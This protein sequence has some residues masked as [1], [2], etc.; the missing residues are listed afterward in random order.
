MLTD[1]KFWYIIWQG[2]GEVGPIL[3]VA[4]Y[5]SEGEMQLVNTEKG[6]V[7]RYV[8]TKKLTANETP[9]P[10]KSRRKVITNNGNEMILYTQA[11]FGRIS[12][13][14]ELRVFLNGE[15]KKDKTRTPISEQ[16][17]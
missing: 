7:L 4:V 14:E 1:Y 17:I 10:H 5:F 16:L 12:S 2:P 3:E 8:R 13:Y 9:E 11:D 15:L 6:Q